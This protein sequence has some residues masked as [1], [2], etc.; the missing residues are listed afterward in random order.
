MFL[1]IKTRVIVR[2][3]HERVPEQSTRR[4]P[5]CRRANKCAVR[6]S[7]ACFRNCAIGDRAQ[8]LSTDELT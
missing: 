6:A 3:L 1:S 8:E 7:L 2:Q 4:F 5:G